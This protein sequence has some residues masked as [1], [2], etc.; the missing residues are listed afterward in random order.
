[1]QQE[2]IKLSYTRGMSCVYGLFSSKEPDRVRYVGI[3]KNENADKRMAV[4][5]TSARN[6]EKLARLP[7]YKWIKKHEADGYKI[8]YVL[9]ETGLSWDEACYLEIAYIKDYRALD[10]GI[11]NMTDGGE[12][13]LGGKF[14]EESIEKIR[15]YWTPER[16]ELQMERGKSR[17]KHVFT[18]EQMERMSESAK[19]RHKRL[20]ESGLVWGLDVGPKDK[21]PKEV[22]DRIFKERLDGKSYQKIAND[23]NR[24]E[25]PTANQRKWYPTSVKNICDRQSPEDF[26]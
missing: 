8:G 14:S 7:V 6:N 18:D 20:R 23:L 11:L 4:H 25:I 21:T 5:L 24:D 19:G 1:M 22:K 15:A 16:R 9:I 26:V 13:F 12:G 2:R 10:S 3:S 17:P